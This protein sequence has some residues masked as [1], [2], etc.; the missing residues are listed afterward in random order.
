MFTPSVYP[1]KKAF[2]FGSKMQAE[3][4]KRL[5]DK[6]GDAVMEGARVIVEGSLTFSLWRRIEE[7]A[8]DLRSC[9]PALVP[10]PASNDLDRQDA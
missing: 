7:F 8:K 10:T 9:R 1:L 5:A 2:E 6:Y 3:T 4:F